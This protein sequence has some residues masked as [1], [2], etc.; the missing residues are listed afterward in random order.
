M[1]GTEPRAV[2]TGCRHSTKNDW[3][4]GY[5]IFQVECLHPVATAPGFVTSVARFHGLFISLWIEYP[6][7]KC[8]AIFIRPLRG[9]CS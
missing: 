7:L 8:W 9:Q 1:L 4:S 3:L 2:A 5:S 6:A